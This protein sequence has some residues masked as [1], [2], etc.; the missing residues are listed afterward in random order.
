MS[1]KLLS[2][3]GDFESL[4]MAVVNGADEIYLGVKDF[5][6]RN[7]IAGFSMYD[8][9]QA[10]DYAHL[11]GVRVFLT[12]NI[13][14]KDDEMQ[15]ALDQIVDANNI[16]VDAFI[17]QD[18]GLA[19]LVHTHFPSIEMHASTQIGIHNLEGAKIAKQMG[20]KRAVLARETPLDEIKRIKQNL[21]IEIEYFVQGAL[22]VC[23]SGNC[24]MSS[25]LFDASGNRGKCKQLCR[26][27]Y[28][29]RYDNNVVAS[30]YLLSAKDFN[31]LDRLKDLESAGVDSIKIEGRARRPYYVGVATKTYRDALDHKSTK[32][33]DLALAFNRGF[34]EGY[35]NGNANIISNKQNHIGIEI[36]KVKRVNLGKKFNEIFISSNIPLNPE[37]SFKFFRNDQEIATISAFDLKK[38]NNDYRITTKAIVKQG[39]VVNIISDHNKEIEMLSTKKKIVQKISVIA[40]NN[41]KIQA[42][43]KIFDK[44]YTIFGEQLLSAQNA[45]ITKQDITNCFE[46]SEY[47]TSALD[48]E[49]E[50]VFIQKSKLNEFRRQVYDFIYSVLTSNKNQILNHEKIETPLN[51]KEI[52]DAQFVEDVNEPIYSN[53]IIFD[54]EIYDEKSILQFK[55]IVENQ[56]KIFILNLPNFALKTDVE[57]LKNLVEKN[58]IN[59][60]SNN[61]WSMDFDTKIYSGFG[62]NVYNSFTANYFG[63]PFIKAENNNTMFTPYMT[64]RHCPMKQHLNANCSNCPFKSGYEYVMQSGSRFKL[65]RKKLSTCTFYLSK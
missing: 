25:Y 62:L 13:L 45:P 64:L 44:F 36:G 65:K 41:T 10:T 33:N 5:N 8:L 19:H 32:N 27:P 21:D 52:T 18:M 61:L 57:M 56:N 9:K 35:F 48:I 28:D 50:N 29:L 14:F 31:M 11:Y 47:F 12:I 26:L 6:A 4:K 46:K 40:K 60:L 37:S 34:T 43:F 30:G 24:Y 63:H 20:F 53:I 54:P 22:C 49:L 1:M 16:G 15:S 51:P 17:I 55:Q 3:V 38:I 23:F 39:D 59:I 42:N 7:N 2:P 58:K